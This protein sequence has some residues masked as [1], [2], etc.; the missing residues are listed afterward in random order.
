MSGKPR[1]HLAGFAC[2]AKQRETSVWLESVTCEK[3]REGRACLDAL[4]ES[5]ECGRP[6][7]HDGPH[8]C[9]IEWYRQAKGTLVEWTH[10][11]ERGHRTGGG[12]NE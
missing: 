2:G 1:V 10:G 3:C 7:G 6:K 12:E 8:R 5:I 11:C 9:F 4:E